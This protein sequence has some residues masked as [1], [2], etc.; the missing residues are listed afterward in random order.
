MLGPEGNWQGPEDGSITFATGHDDKFIYFAAHVRDD[1]VLPEKDALDV[2]IDS[3]DP[4]T[5]AGDTRLQ[6][7]A[8]RF[9]F[10]APATGKESKVRVTPLGRGTSLKGVQGVARRTNEGYDVELAVPVTLFN[11]GKNVDWH[12]FQLGV[13]QE[14]IDQ[15]GD[16][17]NEILWR[18][19]K[20]YLKRNTN[21][22]HF[23]NTK[24]KP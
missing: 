20:D 24:G 13:V 16:K 17:P 2:L 21:F 10:D 22:G 18:G 15:E 19:S 11:R 6:A 14:D 3:R 7:G 8:Y 12:S 9:R 23:L 4:S 5:R 1:R